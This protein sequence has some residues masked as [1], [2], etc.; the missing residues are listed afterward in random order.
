MI[1]PA[2]SPEL[3]PAE[4]VFEEVRR[5]VEGRTYATL[6]D[7]Q[8]AVERFLD[9]LGAAPAR[10]RALAGWAWR[11]AALQPRAEIPPGS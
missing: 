6:A 10:S 8:Q 3:N 7:Q 4:R 1:Q 5:A 2:T 11:V 9:A